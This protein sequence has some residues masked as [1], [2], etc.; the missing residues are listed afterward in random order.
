MNEVTQELAER[1][2]RWKQIELM[3]GFNII[4]NSGLAVLENLLYRGTANGRSIGL[5]GKHCVYTLLLI[6]LSVDIDED[7]ILIFF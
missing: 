7:S 4:N 2:H 1:V 5:R 3:C 6:S